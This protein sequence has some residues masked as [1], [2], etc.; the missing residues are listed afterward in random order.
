MKDAQGRY[1]HQACAD[2]LARKQAPAGP[3]PAPVDNGLGLDDHND[4][5]DILGDSAHA[6]TGSPSD[7]SAAPATQPLPSFQPAATKRVRG[8]SPSIGLGWLSSAWAIAAVLAAIALTLAAASSSGPQGF[9][10][11]AVY[12]GCLSSVVT[13]WAVAFAFRNGEAAWGLLNFLGAA[14][15]NLP[16]LFYAFSRGAANPLKGSLIATVVTMPISLV[17]VGGFMNSEFM[18][19]F[20][21]EMEAEAAAF[22]AAAEPE[23]DYITPSGTAVNIL[24]QSEVRPLVQLCDA[25]IQSRQMNGDVPD[26][27]RAEYNR[28]LQFG[29]DIS[30]YPEDIVA[31]AEAWYEQLDEASRQMLRDGTFFD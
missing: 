19:E 5:D 1:A 2:Q 7:A 22:Q 12:V 23:Y 21:A 8:G 11:F 24:D 14:F 3:T 4:W 13:I 17:A 9:A 28:L 26:G 16:A 6:A 29:E 20:A 15:L 25:I 30:E 31:E 18:Q 10:L 27:M